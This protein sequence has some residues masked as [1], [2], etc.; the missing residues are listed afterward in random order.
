MS[1]VVPRAAHARVADLPRKRHGQAVERLD[2]DV[3]ERGDDP[4]QQLDAVRLREKR[5]LLRIDADADDEPV[6]NAAA[7]P[8][9]VEVSVVDGV[10]RARVDRD[11]V[12]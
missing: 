3:A 1:L 11:A 6:E 12:A 7:A 4:P 8:D 2:R 10:E 9:H 5:R